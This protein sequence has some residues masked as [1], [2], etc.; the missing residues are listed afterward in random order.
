MNKK[1]NNVK[2]LQSL[3]NGYS[4]REVRDIHVDV[5]TGK[6]TQKGS[7]IALYQGKK[8]KLD[9]FKNKQEAIDFLKD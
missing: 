1:V 3:D 5:K 6:K 9:G 4:I 8:M 2:I 7:T